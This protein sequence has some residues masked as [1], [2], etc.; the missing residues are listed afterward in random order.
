MLQHDYAIKDV[1][2]QAKSNNIPIGPHYGAVVALGNMNEK[3]PQHYAIKDVAVQPKSNNIPIRP[4][5]RVVV[6]LGN[7]N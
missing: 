2:V 4:L 3:M 1:A 5:Y 7:M 6:V